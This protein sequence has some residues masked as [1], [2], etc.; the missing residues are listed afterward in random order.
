ML[1]SR[2]LYR[3]DL[4]RNRSFRAVPH[5]GTEHR[6][7]I[8]LAD[9][10]IIHL[11]CGTHKKADKL[12]VASYE[13]YCGCII[14]SCNKLIS[15]RLNKASHAIKEFQTLSGLAG[16]SLLGI[17]G[18][19]GFLKRNERSYDN[20]FVKEPATVDKAFLNARNGAFKDPEA[21]LPPV[22]TVIR[23][24]IGILIKEPYTV[25]DIPGIAIIL[26]AVSNIR[27]DPEHT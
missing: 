11:M 27:R 23:I 16:Q 4:Q 24:N 26:K 22:L 1:R 17:N 9:L 21:A 12:I 15:Q 5:V 25:S 6:N 14:A 20:I 3:I 13:S 7:E 18:F 19:A 8:L 2:Y 10:T